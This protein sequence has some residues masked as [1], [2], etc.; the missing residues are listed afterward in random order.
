M[1]MNPRKKSSGSSGSVRMGAIIVV[2][3]LFALGCVG[4]AYATGYSPGKG[5]QSTSSVGTPGTKGEAKAYAAGLKAHDDR[6]RAGNA[7]DIALFWQK[8]EQDKGIEKQVAELAAGCKP[9]PIVYLPAPDPVPPFE[10]LIAITIPD[11][12]GNDDEAL[13]G[14]DRAKIDAMERTHDQNQD[15]F[16]R[17]DDKKMRYLLYYEE[18]IAYYAHPEIRCPQA[19]PTPGITPEF[20]HFVP[21]VPDVPVITQLF[22]RDDIQYNPDTGALSTDPPVVDLPGSPPPEPPATPTPPEEEPY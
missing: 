3:L 22:K 1:K 4:V 10:E 16:L 12:R 11:I 18:R 19:E 17:N 21:G 14:E 13:S 8:L 2:I 15:K 20:P 6:L 9:C 5:T 7:N